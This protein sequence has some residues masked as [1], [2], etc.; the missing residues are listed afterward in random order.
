MSFADNADIRSPE[1]DIDLEVPG[2]GALSWAGVAICPGHVTAFRTLSRVSPDPGRTPMATVPGSTPSAGSAGSACVVSRPVEAHPAVSLPGLVALARQA[3]P[4]LIE[5][6]V[7]P[8]TV[9]YTALRFT[10]LT[11]ALAAALAWVYGA[12]VWRLL[13]R[14]RVSATMIL[15]VIAA[16]ARAAV[17]L[18]SG[19]AVIYFLQPELGT[20][21]I[22]MAFLASA[23][24]RRPLVRKLVLDYIHLPEAVIKH[25][26]VRRFFIR[27]TVGW[28]MVLLL[29]ATLSIWLL[30][31]QP[32][33]TYLLV[34]PTAVAVISCAAFAGSVGAFRHVLHR[35]AV[36]L[37]GDRAIQTA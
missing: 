33:G 7:V 22:S 19:S 16:T 29:N 24:L 6:V 28:A 11:G 30:L 18:W 4:R 9:F 26:R 13:R 10:G 5:S 32:I 20:I 15:A 2:Q 17:A 1:N 25:A 31:S 37:A 35:L 12:V 21:C 34:R 36:E 8:L 27:L 3:A 14:H 23:V